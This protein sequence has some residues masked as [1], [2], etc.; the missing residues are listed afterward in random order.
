M[1]EQFYELCGTGEGSV[2]GEEDLAVVQL[3]VA[4]VKEVVHEQVQRGGL[5]TP[6]LTG[7]V[8]DKSR[9]RTGLSRA[10]GGGGDGLPAQ[11]D[12]IHCTVL[13]LLTPL[14]HRVLGTEEAG[15]SF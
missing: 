10:G 2:G 12:S 13:S 15:S 1:E 5:E 4:A 6:H 9:A 7:P 8:L 3:L 14:L 11:R